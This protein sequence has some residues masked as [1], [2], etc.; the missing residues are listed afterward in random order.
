MQSLNH[1]VEEK[2]EEEEEGACMAE[3]KQVGIGAVVEDCTLREAQKVHH[4][5]ILQPIHKI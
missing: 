1:L 4:P 2:D 3:E 5:R